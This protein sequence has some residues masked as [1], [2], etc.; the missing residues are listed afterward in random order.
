MRGVAAFMLLAVSFPGDA[1]SSQKAPGGREDLDDFMSCSEILADEHIQDADKHGS[2][3]YRLLVGLYRE[4]ECPAPDFHSARI[5]AVDQRNVQR[6]SDPDR[7]LNCV[8][9]LVEKT[10]LDELTEWYSTLQ[11]QA[12]PAL[13]GKNGEGGRQNQSPG[14][15]RDVGPCARL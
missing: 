2:K 11:G 7:A 8:D 6:L 14:F 4:K 10:W 15:V 3:R 5:G 9:L 13:L 1:S 12:S